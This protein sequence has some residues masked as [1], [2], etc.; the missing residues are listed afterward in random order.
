MKPASIV[1]V[2]AGVVIVGLVS[3]LTGLHDTVPTWMP[4]LAVYLIGHGVGASVPTTAL[5]ALRLPAATGP[6]PAVSPTTSSAPSAVPP[7]PA[8]PSTPAAAVS[9]PPIAAAVVPPQVTA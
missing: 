5:P 2:A 3:L 6:P 7:A 4:Y 1:T 9:V 8:V